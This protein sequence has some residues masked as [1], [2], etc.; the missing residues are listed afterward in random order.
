MTIDLDEKQEGW[1]SI[2]MRKP[3]KR[4]LEELAVK[5]GV[6]TTHYL[7]EVIRDHIK[8]ADPQPIYKPAPIPTK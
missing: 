2:A 4:R 3:L 5:R 6:N 7:E 8:T 1:T